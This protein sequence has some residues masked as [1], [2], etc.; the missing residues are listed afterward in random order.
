MCTF[1][2][3]VEKVTMIARCL[4]PEVI[5]NN[6]V[7]Q[8]SLAHAFCH[9]IGSVEDINASVAQRAIMFLE[10]IRPTALKVS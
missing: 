10:T 3:T 2:S 8:T 6:Q 4:E 1:S 7:I 9:L 5:R